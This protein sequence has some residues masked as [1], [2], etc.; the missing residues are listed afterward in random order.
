MGTFRHPLTLFAPSGGRMEIVDAMVDSGSTFSWITG[1]VLGR[2]GIRPDRERVFIMA[3]GHQTRLGMAEVRVELD[4]EQLTTLVVFA[5]EGSEPL[6][7]A[8]TLEAFS[9]AVDVTNRRLIP[10]PNYAL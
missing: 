2:L 3:D 6:L 10:A 9:L 8:Y 4:G 7:G 1:S 5:P